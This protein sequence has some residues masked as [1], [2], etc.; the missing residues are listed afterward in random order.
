MV[1]DYCMVVVMVVVWWLYGVCVVVV[2]RLCGGCGLIVCVV[3][4][5]VVR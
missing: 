5:V 1:I 3:V 4:V 2:W